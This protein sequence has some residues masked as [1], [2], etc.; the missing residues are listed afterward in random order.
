MSE[1]NTQIVPFNSPSIGDAILLV[2]RWGRT[3]HGHQRMV[4]LDTLPVPDRVAMLMRDANRSLSSPNE[5]K[6]LAYGRRAHELVRNAGVKSQLASFLALEGLIHRL[7]QLT[8][9][10]G[11]IDETLANRTAQGQMDW[12][13]LI[14]LQRSQHTQK[15]EILN[16]LDKKKFDGLH[17]VVT[18][19]SQNE[20]QES[21]KAGLEDLSQLAP[22]KRDKVA[23]LLTALMKTVAMK[24]EVDAEINQAITES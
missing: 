8:I 17:Q 16:F 11:L 7:S 10:N 14:A 12:N 5:D 1:D 13:Q 4:L 3:V 18:A 23:K 6:D 22:G 19:L 2:E 15:M 21:V 20:V 9:S 24:S